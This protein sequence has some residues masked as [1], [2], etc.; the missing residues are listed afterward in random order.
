MCCKPFLI[1]KKVNDIF[2]ELSCVQA[3]IKL[4][5]LSLTYYSLN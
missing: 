5:I 4:P 1:K 3:Y 2:A